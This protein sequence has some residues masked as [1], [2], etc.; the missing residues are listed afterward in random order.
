MARRRKAIRIGVHGRNWDEIVQRPF[1]GML[2]AVEEDRR[3]VVCDYRIA[4]GTENDSKDFTATDPPWTGKVDGMVLS[5][6]LG[7]AESPAQVA[8]W[9]A[10]GGAPVVS[11]AADV[12]H[13]RI[14]TVCFDPVS[15]ARLAADH[16]IECGCR[17]FLYVGFA[18]SMGSTRRAEAFETVL[19]GHGFALDRYDFGSKVEETT[20]DLRIDADARTLAPLLKKKP[21]PVGVLVL[22]DPFARAVWQVCDELALDVP[23]QVAIVGVNDL[24]IAF[25][26]RPTITSIR[27]PGEEVGYRATQLLVK[28]IEG[29]RRPRKPI[30]VRA[31]KLIARES[32]A[33]MASTDDEVRR[34]LDMIRQQACH[35]L[36]T[37]DIA[38]ALAVSRRSLELN[39]RKRL[40]RSVLHE[41]NRVRLATAQKLLQ[42]TELPVC[43]IAAMIGFAAPPGLTGFFKK[44]TSLT[45]SEYRQ[46]AREDE[47]ADKDHKRP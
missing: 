4:G 2:R 15:I 28:L 14:P 8:D 17:R 13:P 46:W 44:H 12:L 20:D 3:L 6:G 36:R 18:R 5:I 37:Q 39:F 21:H 10:R 11:I 29:G 22:G 32:T 7:D 23:E 41:I 38:D 45:P 27:Y 34:A 1:E 25:A 35:G 24:P 40:G 16:L 43:Q 30:I 31:R 9:I 42:A 47:K 26:H 33:G 19:A